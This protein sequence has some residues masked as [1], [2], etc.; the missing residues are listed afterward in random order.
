MPKRR[1]VS[2]KRD[3]GLLSIRDEEAAQLLELL[4]LDCLANTRYVNFCYNPSFL[5]KA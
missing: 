2:Q 3:L 4:T 1:A 5:P